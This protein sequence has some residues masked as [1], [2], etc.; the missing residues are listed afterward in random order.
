MKLNENIWGGLSRK[1][2]CD[3]L[4]EKDCGLIL[5]W[6]NAVTTISPIAKDVKKRQ[7]DINTFEDYPTH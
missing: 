6:W 2:H 4:N 3:L 5:R 7:I 1:Q